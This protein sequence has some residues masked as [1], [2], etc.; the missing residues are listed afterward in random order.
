MT[1]RPEP[2]PLDALL[3]VLPSMPRPILARLTA[4][5]I[6]RLDEMDGDPDDED[7]G[8]R[9]LVEERESEPYF[10]GYADHAI[11]NSRFHV[12]A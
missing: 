8:D 10:G 6:D 7:N 3:S 4:R 2:Q 9:E 12:T 11:D 1:T 5:L